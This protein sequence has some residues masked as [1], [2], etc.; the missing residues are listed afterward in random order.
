M[1][2][3]SN[4]DHDQAQHCAIIGGSMIKFILKKLTV[5]LFIIGLVLA[6]LAPDKVVAADEPVHEVLVNIDQTIGS[7]SDVFDEISRFNRD[8][9]AIISKLEDPTKIDDPY[10]K[11]WY[12]LINIKGEIVLDPEYDIMSDY[13]NDYW[14]IT[15][16]VKDDYGSLNGLQGLVSKH[17]GSIAFD[18]K[19]S[20]IPSFEGVKFDV[21][22]YYIT[23]SVEGKSKFVQKSVV[24]TNQGGVI[25]VADVPA[26]INLADYDGVS[27][28]VYGDFNF[29]SA[30][31]KKLANGVITWKN[32][33]WL[34]NEY[35]NKVNDITFEQI[36]EMY[37][38]ED[39]A[40]FINYRNYNHTNGSP[41][42]QGIMKISRDNG[43][44]IVKTFLSSISA[45]CNLWINVRDK[46][47]YYTDLTSKS[48]S[49]FDLVTE[50][51]H[52]NISKETNTNT[53][54]TCAWQEAP[55]GSGQ[56][57]LCSMAKL[58]GTVIL[59]PYYSD[60]RY[61]GYGYYAVSHLVGDNVLFGIVNESGKIILDLKYY[62]IDIYKGLDWVTLFGKTTV[63]D[64]NNPGKTFKMDSVG[65]FDLK[66]GRKVAD[67]ISYIRWDQLVTEGYSEVGV[68]TGEG[69]SRLVNVTDEFGN[70]EGTAM[71]YVGEETYG[72]LSK[73]GYFPLEP[74]Y[75]AIMPLFDMS[76]QNPKYLGFYEIGIKE[77]THVC[78]SRN[79]DSN[80]KTMV[81]E[82]HSCDVW[83]YGIFS[84]DQG[85]IISPAYTLI[86][87][88]GSDIIQVQ[89]SEFVRNEVIQHVDDLGKDEIFYNAGLSMAK[90]GL[91]NIRTG[92]IVPPLYSGFSST[93][94]AQ[95]NQGSS[96]RLDSR[97]LLKIYKSNYDGV[98][99]DTFFDLVGLVNQYG[100]FVQP[101]YLDLYIKN[102]YL[103]LKHKDSSWTVKNLS[104]MDQSVTISND[105]V[106]GTDLESI[107][108]FDQY[109][110]VEVKVTEKLNTY[111]EYGI[112]K[113][114]SS[115][116]LPIA[117]TSIT[118]DGTYWYLE[119]YDK[120]TGSYPRA[121]MDLNKKYI[122][123][124]S[125]NYDS[126]SEFVGGY[127][128][129]QSGTKTTTSGN[130]TNSLKRAQKSQQFVLNIINQNGIVVSDLSK[131]YE[132]ATLL[133]EI[134]GVARALVK[135]DGK[136]YFATLV[137]GPKIIDTS[138]PLNINWLFVSLLIIGGGLGGG[139]WVILK[140]K[141]AAN[142]NMKSSTQI[143]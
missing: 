123:E 22:N 79:Y 44:I 7:L 66:T 94:E 19:Y 136:Y 115:E 2:S 55:S 84:L 98:N 140:K 1:F 21:M 20:E 69:K 126:L 37:F 25:G 121:I 109:I 52:A 120:M 139:T 129:G 91:I 10:A 45:Y 106:E 60:I 87:Y 53:I 32:D 58:D 43:K 111:S 31:W 92:E 70:I 143:K 39:G 83:R 9:I 119:K 90:Y 141:K 131:E 142:C 88:N 93:I 4:E 95:P 117:F 33:T 77:S 101:D 15:K 103:Y 35:G 54:I 30:Q 38:R 8:G 68:L 16:L 59:E 133:G 5:V 29:I 102:G 100:I 40:V 107:Q 112:Y 108:L 62:G 81:E 24:M 76:E 57:Y 49:Y 104:D 46:R 36:S 6:T 17:D 61:L 114:D 47:V 12:G 65:F 85:M 128:V 11:R 23:Q 116:Y 75:G 42:K 96:S 27:K 137:E 99:V 71:D 124:F 18:V 34:V 134:D 50:T 86:Q 110:M 72:V 132:S 82:T 26:G 64:Q 63:N 78:G 135:K 125:S 56:V 13:N 28:M 80:T 51:H 3:N 74:I 48:E 14:T 113:S 97:G 41:T 89:R 118:F 122:V 138:R 73:E 130:I 105:F 67:N 127:A